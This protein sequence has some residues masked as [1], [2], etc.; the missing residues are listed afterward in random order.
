M[1]PIVR[2]DRLRV[3]GLVSFYLPNHL[4]LRREIPRRF[5]PFCRF[6]HAKQGRK[7]YRR[8]RARLSFF[9]GASVR[10]FTHPCATPCPFLLKNEQGVRLACVRPVTSI[11]TEPGSNPHQ[12]S[13][14]ERTNVIFFTCL[15]IL[16]CKGGHRN[17]PL[18]TIPLL[19]YRY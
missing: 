17:A 4:S 1:W 9:L 6:A 13:G 19:G 14:K 8:F 3:V 18:P 7:A 2:E 16:H 12:L 5:T 11:P 15:N 10:R